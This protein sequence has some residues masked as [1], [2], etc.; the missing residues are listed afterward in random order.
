MVSPWAPGLTEVH[1]KTPPQSKLMYSNTVSR[2]HSDQVQM[3][4]TFKYDS[5]LLTGDAN[6]SPSPITKAAAPE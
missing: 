1:T 5:M 6:A 3:P 2:S 4:K